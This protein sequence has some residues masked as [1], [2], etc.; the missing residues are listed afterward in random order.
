[1]IPLG[2]SRFWPL[3]ERSE[4]QRIPWELG[5]SRPSGSLRANQHPRDRRLWKSRA[6]ALPASPARPHLGSTRGAVFTTSGARSPRRPINQEPEGG[7]R[8]RFFSWA[9]RPVKSD[10]SAEKASWRNP[11]AGWATPGR[12]CE[13]VGASSCPVRSAQSAFLLRK[14]VRPG[15]LKSADS[16]LLPW[17]RDRTVFNAPSLL[18]THRVPTTF[19]LLNAAPSRIYSANICGRRGLDLLSTYLVQCLQMRRE[20]GTAGALTEDSL[21]PRKRHQCGNK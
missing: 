15:L 18:G 2:S 3:K 5:G 1:M 20:Q 8:H 14:N 13:R 17:C 9:H 6:R 10:C 16:F 7:V 21:E 4:S 19:S 12:G 11:F